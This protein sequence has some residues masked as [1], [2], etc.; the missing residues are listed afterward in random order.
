M[1]D[2]IDKHDERLLLEAERDPERSR[3]ALKLLNG[4]D[5]TRVGS[6]SQMRSGEWSWTLTLATGD[7]G[8]GRFA[9]G[10]A[11]T[12]EIARDRQMGE[13]E[14]CD[15]ARFGYRPEIAEELEGTLQALIDALARDGGMTLKQALQSTDPRSATPEGLVIA[16]LNVVTADTDTLERIEQERGA[17]GIAEIAREALERHHRLYSGRKAGR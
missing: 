17:A 16:A 3:L 4:T 8:P 13:L 1:E 14:A 2:V 7:D 10:V 11:R 15:V 6:I 9:D 12:A 5:A